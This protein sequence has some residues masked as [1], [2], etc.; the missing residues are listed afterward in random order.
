MAGRVKRWSSECHLSLL[1][2]GQVA[3]E[4]DESQDI[5]GN[6]D[7][8][9]T[10]CKDSR[11]EKAFT[12]VIILCSLTSQLRSLHRDNAT[13]RLRGCIISLRLLYIIRYMVLS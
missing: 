9:N 2:D 12:D 13:E 8:E 1:R 5:D 6:P 10:I 11:R 4:F 3:T 7:A